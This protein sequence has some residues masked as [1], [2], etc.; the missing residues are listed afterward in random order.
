VGRVRSRVA[1]AVAAAAVLTPLLT[2]PLGWQEQAVFATALILIAAVLNRTLRTTTVTLV[3]MAMSVF[4]TL[5]YGYWRTTQTW[6]GITSAG[7]FQQFDTIFILL[8]LERFPLRRRNSVAAMPSV[9]GAFVGREQ[10]ERHGS[11]ATDLVVGAWTGG[12][13]ERFQFGK[14]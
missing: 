7:H 11:K 14:R 2:L 13:Q 1:I 10:V 6:D 9:I 12:A 3:L 5:R 4:S 8:M